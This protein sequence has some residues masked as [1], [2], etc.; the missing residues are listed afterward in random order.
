M[1]YRILPVARK[2]MNKWIDTLVEHLSKET[3]RTLIPPLLE[4]AGFKPPYVKEFNY[5]L[6]GYY[7]HNEYYNYVEKWRN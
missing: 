7:E 1:P 3:C 2:K 6:K 5:T 4:K